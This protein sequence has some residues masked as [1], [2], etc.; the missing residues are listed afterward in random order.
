M[1]Q[2]LITAFLCITLVA[3]KEGFVYNYTVCPT[4]G[5]LRHDYQL[6]AQDAPPGMQMV[7]VL[8]TGQTCVYIVPP[9]I[10]YEL[11]ANK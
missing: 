7:V 11:R 4:N 5:Q 6:I 9:R 2:M 3:C 1:Y 8:I 10:G